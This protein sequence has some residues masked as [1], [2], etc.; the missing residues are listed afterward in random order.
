MDLSSHRLANALVGNLPDCATLE[1]AFVGPELEFEDD[2]TIA[3]AGATFAVTVDGQSVPDVTPVRLKRGAHLRFGAR[4]SGA[5][6]YLAISGGIGTT[7]VLGSRA[8]H[9]AS[10]VG[11]FQGRALVAGDRV[12]LGSEPG[13]KG[14]VPLFERHVGKKG[15][16]PVSSVRV[17]PGPHLDRLSAGSLD[18]LQSGL[19][20]VTPQSDRIGYRLAGPS[21]PESAQTPMISDPTPIGSLQVPSSGQPILLMADRQTVGGYPIVATVI[22]ADLGIAGQLAPGDSLSF[23]TVTVGD[24]LAALV[25]EE[26]VLMSLE[27]RVR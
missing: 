20:V 11:G 19:Y 9:V 2:R 4:S 17:L 16:G 3:I 22:A 14:A 12:P 27:G 15:Y 25:A 7:P 26:Q 23:K 18:V 24:A 8:T 21:I 1:V 10:R 6:A 13:G 5:R